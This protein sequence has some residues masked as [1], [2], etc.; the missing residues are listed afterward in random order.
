MV[1]SKQTCPRIC[2]TPQC[3]LM[4]V[5]I[6]LGPGKSLHN[7]YNAYEGRPFSTSPATSEL[8]GKVIVTAMLASVLTI[9]ANAQANTLANLCSSKICRKCAAQLLANYLESLCRC[10]KILHSL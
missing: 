5:I 8:N 7:F 6:P 10:D 2:K 1:T 4:R 9:V 3:G